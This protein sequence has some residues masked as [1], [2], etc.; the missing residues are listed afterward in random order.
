MLF[1]NSGD[2]QIFGDALA[3]I[4]GQAVRATMC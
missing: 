2:D 4:R 3:M 1:G